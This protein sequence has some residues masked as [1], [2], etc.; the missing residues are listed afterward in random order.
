MFTAT[1]KQP[2][3]LAFLVWDDARTLLSA[4]VG[5]CWYRPRGVMVAA[6]I[7]GIPAEARE[8]VVDDDGILNLELL[9]NECVALHA[10]LQGILLQRVS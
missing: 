5:S 10:V 3:R 7:R 2:F 1:S 8:R 6:T 4:R 9:A